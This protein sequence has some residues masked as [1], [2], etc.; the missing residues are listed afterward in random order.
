MLTLASMS[1]CITLGQQAPNTTACCNPTHLD[2][3]L[4]PY[5]LHV[6]FGGCGFHF[7]GLV[8]FG[9]RVKGHVD[10]L[11]RELASGSREQ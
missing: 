6:Q 11:I 4:A 5:V 9:G 7:G 10:K 3:P 2:Q 1:P 8:E